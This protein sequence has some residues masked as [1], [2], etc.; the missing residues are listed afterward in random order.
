MVVMMGSISLA[1]RIYSFNLLFITILYGM[2]ISAGVQIK[3]AF[4]IG[5]RKHSLAQKELI[6]GVKIGVIGVVVFMT[7]LIS[8][9][10]YFYSIFTEN[11]EIWLLGTSLLFVAILGELGRSFNLIVGASLRAC[12]DAKYTS[13]IGFISMWFIAVPLAWLFGVH[14]AWGLVGVWLGT[15]IDEAIRGVSNMRRWHSKRWQAKGL[16]AK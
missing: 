3:V 16:Y 12:G 2:A 9:S 6:K 7:I 13:V 11:K 4:L 1:T 14:L 8:Y 10:H 5:A 15:S